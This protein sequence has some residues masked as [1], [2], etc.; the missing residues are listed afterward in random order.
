VDGP[1]ADLTDT[2]VAAIVGDVDVARLTGLSFARVMG[3]LFG[4]G[5][6]TTCLAQWE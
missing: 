1:L 2:R 4:H 3:P 6:G 5:L